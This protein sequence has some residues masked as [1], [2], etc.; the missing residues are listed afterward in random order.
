MLCCKYR[1]QIFLCVDTNRK[2]AYRMGCRE[3]NYASAS[4][5]YGSWFQ[6]SNLNFIEVF[7]PTYDIVRSNK[8]HRE[9]V[10]V[11]ESISQ[12]L[13]PDGGYI[14]H[15]THYMLAEGCRSHNV[16]QFIKFIGIIHIKFPTKSS[17]V[18]KF[19]FI[20]I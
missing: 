1:S 8:H 14:Y 18:S 6:Q 15:L 4:I 17:I 19:Y 2:V 20:F 12:Y 5:R 7:F 9:H 10:A 3:I 11:F 16:D 13:R